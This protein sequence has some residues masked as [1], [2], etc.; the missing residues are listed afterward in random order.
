MTRCATAMIAIDMKTW[1]NVLLDRFY[2][3]DYQNLAYFILILKKNE[4][5]HEKNRKITQNWTIQ[6]KDR[7]YVTNDKISSESIFI[8][9]LGVFLSV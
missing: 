2:D 1:E 6:P 4:I 5:L 8:L 9:T 7:H 3:D